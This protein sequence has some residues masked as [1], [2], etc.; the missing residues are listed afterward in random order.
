MAKFHEPENQVQQQSQTTGVWHFTRF[1][2]SQYEL[3]SQL[4]T[5]RASWLAINAWL[6]GSGAAPAAAQHCFKTKQ[7]SFASVSSL[8]P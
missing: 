7:P 2:L 1:S 3:A 6:M 4:Y 8:L 5:A